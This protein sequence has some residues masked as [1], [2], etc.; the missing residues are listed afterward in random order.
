MA[1][2]ATYSRGSCLITRDKYRSY[3]FLSAFME[4]LVFLPGP[5]SP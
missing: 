5:R 1:Q 3:V 4:K 2:Y